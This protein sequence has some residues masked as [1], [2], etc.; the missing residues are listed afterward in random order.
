LI[1]GDGGSAAERGFQKASAIRERHMAS[2][3]SVF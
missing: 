2:D 3:S 1:E